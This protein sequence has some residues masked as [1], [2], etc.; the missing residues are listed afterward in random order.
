MGNELLYGHWGY[1]LFYSV[2]WSSFVFVLI[3]PCMFRQFAVFALFVLF[4][5]A[6]FTELYGVPL[7]INLVSRWLAF[8]PQTELFSH[9]SGELW[10]ILFRQAEKAKTG[11]GSGLVF[12]GIGDAVW[13][14]FSPVGTCRGTQLFFPQQPSSTLALVSP[15]STD[16]DFDIARVAWQYRRGVDVRVLSPG[17]M[18]F[19]FLL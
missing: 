2:A 13:F 11:G 15:P 17:F 14:E 6:E 8:Y 3:R 1:V 10:R 9:R 7:S 12:A 5:I 4:L 16:R 19:A 18:V